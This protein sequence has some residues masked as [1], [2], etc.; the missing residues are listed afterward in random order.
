MITQGKKETTYE[1]IDHFIK[2]AVFVGGTNDGFKCWIFKRR[3]R[4]DY[5]FQ[6]NLGLKE[7]H[8]LKYLLRKVHAYI[9]YKEKLLVIGV[10]RGIEIIG[11]N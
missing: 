7:A 10:I 6:E 9:N 4:L 5:M 1:Y 11:P 2:V 8:S 3:L